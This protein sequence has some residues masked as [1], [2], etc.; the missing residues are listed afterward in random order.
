MSTAKKCNY[1]TDVC[2][3]SFRKFIRILVHSPMDGPT[4]HYPPRPSMWGLAG[5]PEDALENVQ[6]M[7]LLME[8]LQD[9]HMDQLISI[10]F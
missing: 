4:I 2:P 5:G 10:V 9:I 6:G 8:M 1:H 7:L 3:H